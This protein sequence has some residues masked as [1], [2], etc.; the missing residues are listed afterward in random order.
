MYKLKVLIVLIFLSFKSFSQNAT[1]VSKPK[2]VILTENQAREVAKDL[3]RYDSAMEVIIEQD[4]R[5]K[6]FQRKEIQ[7][8]NNIIVKDSI[9]FHQSTLIDVLKK[10][11]NKKKSLEI[12]GY[13]GVNSIGITLNNPII[14]TN[15]MFELSRINI[16]AQYYVQPQYHSGYGIIL[17][18]KLF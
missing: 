12:H 4:L 1:Q 11:V 9:I 5:I 18:Y 8:K 10:I 3:V 14:Y 17:E 16:G 6:T 15:L 7:F 2:V 13:R